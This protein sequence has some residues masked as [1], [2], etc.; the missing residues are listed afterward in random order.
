VTGNV[1]DVTI[2]TV[3]SK[4]ANA[5]DAFHHP[6]GTFAIESCGDELIWLI[7]YAFYEIIVR[8]NPNHMRIR[9]YSGC[10]YIVSLHPYISS[11]DFLEFSGG[12]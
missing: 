10:N 8:M 6:L 3:D 11:V 7:Q 12:D 2:A 4:G 1:S 5:F 9:M